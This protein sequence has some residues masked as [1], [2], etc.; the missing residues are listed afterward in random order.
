MSNNDERLIV[1]DLDSLL[2]TRIPIINDLVG[3][4]KTTEILNNGYFTRN[5]NEFPGITFE[6]FQEKW[7]NRNSDILPRS[8][9]TGCVQFLQSMLKELVVQKTATAGHD[10][11]RIMVNIY[12]YEMD[13]E[14]KEELRLVLENYFINLVN[15][16]VSRIPYQYMDYHWV[17]DNVGAMVFYNW[18]DW[19]NEITD[20]FGGS[21]MKNTL[22][23]ITLYAPAIHMVKKTEESEKNF[24]TNMEFVQT[25]MST[26]I[27]LEYIDVSIFSMVNLKKIAQKTKPA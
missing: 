5:S 17:R 20:S 1:V 13:D 26:A 18:C 27:G 21:L 9:M 16:T 2:D 24:V 23:R 15:V 12:P 6:A 3:D 25:C 10:H 7:V 8:M 22:S 19:I 14:E 11:F 4:K